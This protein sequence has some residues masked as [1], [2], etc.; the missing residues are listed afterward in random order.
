MASWQ[1]FW[2]KNIFRLFTRITIK[3]KIQSN[4]L[5]PSTAAEFNSSTLTGFFP[6]E[7]GCWAQTSFSKE[8][9]LLLMPGLPFDPDKPPRRDNPPKRP[10]SLSVAGSYSFILI[11]RQSP[12]LL[13]FCGN[14]PLKHKKMMFN[15]IIKNRNRSFK[16]YISDSVGKQCKAESLR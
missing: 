16:L 3:W 9:S 8:Q 11:I 7:P 4:S 2:K 12:P 10:H 13:S 1:S 15:K 6:S 14:K 5:L